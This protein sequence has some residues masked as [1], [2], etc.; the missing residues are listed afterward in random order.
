MRGA[1]AEKNEVYVSF[2]PFFTIVNICEDSL[3]AQQKN[4]LTIMCVLNKKKCKKIL[5]NIQFSSW[6]HLSRGGG[7]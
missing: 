3:S 2:S 4:F 7:K 6:A 1:K 5:K